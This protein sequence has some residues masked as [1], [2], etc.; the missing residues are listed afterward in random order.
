MVV[1]HH[2]GNTIELKLEKDGLSHKKSGRLVGWNKGEQFVEYEDITGIEFN[3]GVVWGDL[4][5]STSGM[6]INV[7]RVKKNEGDAFVTVLRNK[8]R[9]INEKK[10]GKQEISPM[11]EIKK[12]KELLDSGAITEE[13]FESIKKKYL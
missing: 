9:E 7:E 8:L 5:I 4:E 3:K 11:G 6:K 12:A 2:K 10:Q 1:G 13:E